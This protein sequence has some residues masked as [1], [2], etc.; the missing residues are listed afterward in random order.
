M[1]FRCHIACAIVS[2]ITRLILMTRRSLELK[3]DDVVSC[4]LLPAA[5]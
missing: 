4:Y 1:H 5:F 3:P 2:D